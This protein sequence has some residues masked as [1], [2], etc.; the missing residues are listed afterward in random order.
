MSTKNLRLQRTRY[1]DFLPD[2]RAQTMEDH[3][4]L[5]GPHTGQSTMKDE[6]WEHNG[7]VET[8]VLDVIPGYGKAWMVQVH[9]RKVQ[10]QVVRALLRGRER[11]WKTEAGDQVQDQSRSS[12]DLVSDRGLVTSNSL[13]AGQGLQCKPRS[14]SLKQSLSWLCLTLQ[15]ARG[16]WH[17]YQEQ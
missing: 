16:L 7:D 12:I 6:R 13:H 1:C 5:M 17:H 9:V 14:P 3:R 2:W 8:V 4:G 11:K 15:Q 10:V